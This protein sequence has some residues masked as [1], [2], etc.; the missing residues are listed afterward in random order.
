MDAPKEAKAEIQSENSEHSGSNGRNYS[1]LTLEQRK[2]K[3]R[4]QFITAGIEQ[5]GSKGFHSVTVRGICREA[6]LTDRYFYESFGS[7]ET[8]S[9]AVY[10]HC[11][12]ELVSKILETIGKGIENGTLRQA[13]KAGIDVYFQEVENPQIAQICLLG[14]EG[15]SPDIDQMYNNY[16]QNIAKTYISVIEQAYPNWQ[17]PEDEK[18]VIGLSVVGILRQTAT[19]WVVNGYDKPRTTLVAGTFMLIEGL[20]NLIEG[21]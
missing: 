11:M 7:L 1:G 5:F 17:Q 8:L 6:K 18:A 2:A 10:E 9:M 3:R 14:L 12:N 19:T 21:K 20:L 16:I 13:M 15:I 4:E